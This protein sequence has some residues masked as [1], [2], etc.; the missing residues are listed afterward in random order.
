MASP[1]PRT[2]GPRYRA[3]RRPRAHRAARRTGRL[4]LPP[5]GDPSG[6]ADHPDPDAAAST[7][8]DAVAVQHHDGVRHPRDVTLAEM[9]IESFY[10]ADATTAEYFTSRPSPKK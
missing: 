9:A 6:H 2:P 7:G 5:R 8:R 3:D 10:P 1:P 4:A